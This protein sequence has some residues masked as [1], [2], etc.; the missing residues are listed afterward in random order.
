M[1]ISRLDQIGIDISSCTFC[2]PQWVVQARQPPD[3]R[4]SDAMQSGNSVYLRAAIKD[5]LDIVDVLLL[6]RL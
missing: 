4:L 5:A 1:E 3:S 6:D 2:A